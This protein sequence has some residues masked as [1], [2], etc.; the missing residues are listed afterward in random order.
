MHAFESEQMRGQ[1]GNILLDLQAT[2]YG[3]YSNIFEEGDQPMSV[4]IS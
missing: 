3:T 2:T 4:F 1:Y